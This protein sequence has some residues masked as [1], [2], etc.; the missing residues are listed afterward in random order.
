MLISVQTLRALAALMVVMQH[1]A[2]KAEQYRNDALNDFHIGSFGVD[3]FFIISGYI[4]CHATSQKRVSCTRFIANRIKRIIP[5]YW[6]VT[7]AALVVY[8]VAPSMVNASGGETS[9]FSSWT[10]IPTGNK[11]LVQNGWTLSYE[12]VFYLIFALFLLTSALRKQIVFSSLALTIMVLLGLYF[13]PQQP[14]LKFLTDKI[15]AEF[16]L[17]MLAFIFLRRVPLS[18]ALSLLLLAVGVVLLIL[19]NHYGVY[20]SSAG[21]VLSAG[22]PMLLIFIGSVGLESVIGN[23]VFPG[24]NGAILLGNASYS[25]YLIH[26]FILSPGALILHKLQLAQNQPLFVL[27]LLVSALIAGVLTWRL[28]EQPINACFTQKKLTATKPLAG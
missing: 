1:I 7:A 5:L 21:R 13:Q 25:L 9:I 12:L 20:A 6:I 3:L 18:S 2:D 10:L 27:L 17:G 4:M 19:Q 28:I 22:V 16:I 24:K 8:L 23:S 15:F 26:P 14:T 11:L